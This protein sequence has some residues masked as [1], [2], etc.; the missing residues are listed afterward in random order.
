MALDEVSHRLFT[1]CCSRGIEVL[2]M[3][4]GEELQSLPIPQGVD[5]MEFDQGSALIREQATC[6]ALS[7]IRFTTLPTRFGRTPGRFKTSL[8]SS[9]MSSVTSQTKLAFSAYLHSKSA[10][11]FLPRTND[12]LKPEMPPTSALVST[13]PRG[14]RFLGLDGNGYLRHA[15]FLA[16]G[17][18]GLPNLLIRAFADVSCGLC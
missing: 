17:A 13:T 14:C 3:R 18:N 4:T 2:D 6:S 12:F 16:I 5:D 9:R 1:A 11:G 15:L 10:L 7:R 8:Y